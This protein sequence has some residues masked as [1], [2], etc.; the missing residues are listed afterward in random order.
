MSWKDKYQAGKFRNASFV[1]RRSDFGGG[2]RLA[3]H[4]YPLRDKPY[5]EDLGRRAKRFTLDL[6]VIGKDYMVV[7]DALISALDGKGPGTLQHPYYGGIRVSVEDYRVSEST[8]EGGM[9][10][11]S[12][13]FV[14]SGQNSSP[15]S[16]T[17]TPSIVKSSADGGLT[18]IE[19]VFTSNFTVEKRPEFISTAANSLLSDLSTKVVSLIN[20]APSVPSN[21]TSYLSQANSLSSNS[22]SLIRAPATLANDIT[23]L[24]RGVTGVFDDPLDAL[25]V[26]RGLF[27]FGN[28]FASVPSSTPTRVQ[29]AANQ[30]AIIN[31]TQQAG[32]IEAA[33]VTSDIEFDSFRDARTLRDELDVEFER[34][35]LTT[36]DNSYSALQTVRV[37]MIDDIK[38]RGADLARIVGYEPAATLPALVIAHKLYNDASQDAAIVDRNSLRHPGFVV[39]G[40]ELEVLNSAD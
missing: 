18:T 6:L 12:V 16:S 14:E 19:S 24:L 37:A 8:S 10:T 17:S 25:N 21:I 40:T 7:R 22:A 3:V 36:D 38:V 39:G 29:Q 33:R 35:M 2:R 30:T 31:I 20:D 13:T 27:T 26:Y 9:A 4:E 11:F 1:T 34:Q 5:V 23:Q 28:T 32:L 15:A